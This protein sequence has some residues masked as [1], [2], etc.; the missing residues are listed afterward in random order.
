LLIG[1]ISLSSFINLL[2]AMFDRT[3]LWTY[4]F[5][6]V[7]PV[8]NVYIPLFLSRGFSNYTL[9]IMNY[10]II[11]IPLYLINIL[12]FTEVALLFSAIYFIWRKK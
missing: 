5:D 8:W 1:L 11:N 6:V 4:P 2:G 10:K 7:N 12:F 9:N 3:G